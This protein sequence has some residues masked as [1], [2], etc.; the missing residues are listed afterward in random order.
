MVTTLLKLFI[1]VAITAVAAWSAYDGRA[2]LLLAA[3][4]VLCAG[5]LWV[6]LSSVSRRETALLHDPA[7]ST[8]V[9]PPESKL[10]W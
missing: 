1:G 9:F 7:V 8:L 3:V 5:L 10:H 2:I 4:L 6:R